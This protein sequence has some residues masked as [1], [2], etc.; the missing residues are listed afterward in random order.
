[1]ETLG[2]SFPQLPKYMRLQTTASPFS[3][4]LMACS[5]WADAEAEANIAVRK[6]EIEKILISDSHSQVWRKSANS[7]V[8]TQYVLALDRERRHTLVCPENYVCMTP[9]VGP[10][11]TTGDVREVLPARLFGAKSPALLRFSPF[12]PHRLQNRGNAVI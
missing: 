2:F 9:D 7:A 1:M 3:H 8:S 5:L 6:T 4:A 12:Q 10:A 11:S